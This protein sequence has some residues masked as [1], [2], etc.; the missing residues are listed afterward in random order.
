MI[1][2]CS[3]AV[4]D[5]EILYPLFLF[6]WFDVRRLEEAGRDL[7]T[8][9]HRKTHIYMHMHTDTHSLSLLHTH[10]ICA[11]NIGVA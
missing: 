6:V 3:C 4:S 5:R 10:A 11:F 7:D 8:H 9:T 2:D 1:V